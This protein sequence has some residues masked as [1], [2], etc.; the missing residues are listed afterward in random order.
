MP[1]RSVA[2]LA[3]DVARE[4]SAM[5]RIREARPDLEFRLAPAALDGQRTARALYYRRRG[6]PSWFWFCWAHGPDQ[7]D[8]AAQRI[9]G[10]GAA[11]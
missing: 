8:G 10:E 2:Q 7:L 5:R 3:R 11:R 6:R 9:T 4:W 1:K